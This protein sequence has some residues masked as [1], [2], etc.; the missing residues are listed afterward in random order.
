MFPVS[1]DFMSGDIKTFESTFRISLPFPS[2]TSPCA[3]TISFALLILQAPAFNMDDEIYNI[4]ILHCTAPNSNN[5]LNF[6]KHFRNCC[7]FI[8]KLLLIVCNC[9]PKFSNFDEK[10]SECQQLAQRRG[11]AQPSKMKRYNPYK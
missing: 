2:N 9:C 10:N 1:V 5:H 3:T 7:N 11:Q 8:F 6:V 4:Y